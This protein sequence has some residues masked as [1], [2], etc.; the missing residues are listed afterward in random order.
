M[1]ARLSMFHTRNASHT[2]V[3]FMGAVKSFFKT[4][5]RKKTYQLKSKMLMAL[6]ATGPR[7]GMTAAQGSLQVPSQRVAPTN[8]PGVKSCS[9]LWLMKCCDS[10]GF[11][12]LLASCCKWGAHGRT[13]YPL[14]WL[15][16]SCFQRSDAICH[17]M[18][19]CECPRH[20]K[21]IDGGSLP[22]LLC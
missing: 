10:T 5:K 22:V 7:L 14:K 17:G 16:R 6:A 1:Y 18:C 11:I 12:I 15:C 3:K 19:S 2:L 20:M 8:G 13:C 9:C 4:G 21:A